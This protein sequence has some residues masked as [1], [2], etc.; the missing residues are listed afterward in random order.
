M[1]TSLLFPI[2][3]ML[4]LYALSCRKSKR[5]IQSPPIDLG[6]GTVDDDGA[7]ISTH[8][9]K[10]ILLPNHITTV[11]NSGATSHVSLPNGIKII[12]DGNFETETGTAYTGRVCVTVHSLNL[13]LSGDAGQK[14]QI[15][16]KAQVEMPPTVAQLSMVPAPMC[17]PGLG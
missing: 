7:N 4:V 5:N 14:L 10:M 15:T 1:E 9:V 2:S 11:V 16:N 17:V 8:V 6:Q 3:L 13:A 12:F